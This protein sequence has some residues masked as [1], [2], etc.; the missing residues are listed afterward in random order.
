MLLTE[1]YSGRWSEAV[2]DA[3]ERNYEPMRQF[4]GT[5]ITDGARTQ[6]LLLP[7]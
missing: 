3:I 1:V 7:K 5:F 2:L 6:L 4:D